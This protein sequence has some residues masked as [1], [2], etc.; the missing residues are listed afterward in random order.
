MIPTNQL[1]QYDSDFLFVVIKSLDEERAVRELFDT[2]PSLLR[3]SAIKQKR[4]YFLKWEDW[5]VYAPISINRQL[6]QAVSLFS[7]L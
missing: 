2:N 3:F 4:Y 5:M 1:I 7:K 6:D